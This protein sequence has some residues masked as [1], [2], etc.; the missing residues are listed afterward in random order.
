MA[1][2]SRPD[3]ATRGALRQL[4]LGK[5]LT[6]EEQRRIDAFDFIEREN[7]RVDA[8]KNDL[9]RSYAAQNAKTPSSFN[10][11]TSANNLLNSI[12]GQRQPGQISIASS[13]SAPKVF[14]EGMKTPRGSILGQQESVTID[15]PLPQSKELFLGGGAASQAVPAQSAAPLGSSPI[16]GQTPAP[17]SPSS[18]TPVSI[19]GSKP[20]TP[21]TS[22]QQAMGN[23]LAERRFR[24]EQEQVM[25][26][27]KAEDTKNLIENVADRL[28]VGDSEAI[29]LVPPEFVAAAMNRASA[30]SKDLQ[31]ST[32]FETEEQAFEVGS[33]ANPDAQIFVTPSSSGG[34]TFTAQKKTPAPRELR[35]TSIQ[36]KGSVISEARNL[37]AAGNKTAASDKLNSIGQFLTDPLTGQ[38]ILITSKN[39]SKVFE[40]DED[41][42]DDD[43][44]NLYGPKASNKK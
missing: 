21:T 39:I 37:F 19:L 42:S 34:F 43:L 15:Q 24:S 18:Q 3:Q 4:Q 40:E 9:Y 11:E 7:A 35:P 28:V 29:K 16:L 14:T 31:T 25:D 10:A 27:K 20:R 1:I 41:L 13:A 12:F 22:L 8:E 26:R 36:E 44:F 5:D 17:Y 23:T 38:R 30:K 6:K 33:R 32:S 2:I